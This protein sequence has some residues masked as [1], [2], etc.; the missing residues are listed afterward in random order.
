MTV[1]LPS[2]IHEGRRNDELTRY[3]GALRRRGAD[4]TDLIL[5]LFVANETSCSPP[6]SGREVDSIARSVSKYPTARSIYRATRAAVLAATPGAIV[7]ASSSLFIVTGRRGGR[8][9]VD[10]DSDGGPTCSCGRSMTPEGSSC[11]HTRAA[12][13]WVATAY[14][15]EVG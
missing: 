12:R 3:A 13:V 9:E 10:L 4:R 14:P 8:F 6:L 5:E 7:R 2:V 11:T 1:R 15:L